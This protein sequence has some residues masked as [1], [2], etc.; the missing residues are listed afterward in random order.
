MSVLKD[1]ISTYQ[2]AAHEMRISDPLR[3]STMLARFKDME[4]RKKERNCG[5]S[6]VS[7]DILVQAKWQEVEKWLS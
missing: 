7:V 3:E 4:Q 2:A 1:Q 6:F 5:R